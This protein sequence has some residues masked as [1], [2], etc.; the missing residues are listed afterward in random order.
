[1]YCRCSYNFM[2][3]KAYD[4]LEEMTKLEWSLHLD[5][6]NRKVKEAMNYTFCKRCDHAYF[7]EEM[8]ELQK[9]QV[10]QRKQNAIV[11]DVLKRKIDEIFPSIEMYP[12]FAFTTFI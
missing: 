8:S 4:E 7:L 3:H 9:E 11:G 5:I 12:E 6:R 10:R 2:R 1:M